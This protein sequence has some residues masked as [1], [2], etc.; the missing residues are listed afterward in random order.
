M[1]SSASM[2]TTAFIGVIITLY[3]FVVVLN[4]MFCKGNGKYCNSEC[5]KCK[6]DYNA[7]KK[8]CNG[9][10]MAEED[11]ETIRK[12]GLK[13][14]GVH[15]DYCAEKKRNKRNKHTRKRECEDYMEEGIEARNCAKRDAAKEMCEEEDGGQDGEEEDGGQDGEEE[16]GQK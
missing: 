6:K 13:A 12:V 10:K 11:I 7:L 4:A 2:R 1:Q 5:E 9:T 8:D 3:L 14:F 16:G 15:A